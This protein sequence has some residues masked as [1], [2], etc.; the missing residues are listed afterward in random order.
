MHEEQIERIFYAKNVRKMWKIHEKVI[1]E[2]EK[3]K[4]FSHSTREN[5]LDTESKMEW[6]CVRVNSVEVDSS[7]KSSILTALRLS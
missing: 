5:L 3:K 2:K 7:P 4:I 6:G 1:V